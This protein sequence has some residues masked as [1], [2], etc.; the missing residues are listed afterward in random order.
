MNKLQHIPVYIQ[1][2]AISSYLEHEEEN[3]PSELIP[4]A[5][6]WRKLT[7]LINKGYLGKFPSYFMDGN[8]QNEDYLS[9]VIAM[10][11][12]SKPKV[13]DTGINV[14]IILGLDNASAERIDGG[15][16]LDGNVTFDNDRPCHKDD[17]HSE[18]KD[19]RIPT[20]WN[21]AGNDQIEASNDLKEIKTGL[22]ENNFF[23][24]YPR[25]SNKGGVVTV[26]LN[27]SPSL[28]LG[29]FY[30][31]VTIT[32]GTGSEIDLA[33]GFIREETRN[34][35]NMT[36][37]N[38]DLRAPDD[39]VVSWYGKNGLL[40]V[41][42]GKRDDRQFCT[43]GKGDT[44][45]MGFN[46]IR[47]EFFITKNGNYV[48]ELGSIDAFISKGFEGKINT[49][50]LLPCVCFGS[51][52]G[53]S[54]NLGYEQKQM[55]MFDIEHYVK[56][57][58][59]QVMKKIEASNNFNNTKNELNFIDSVIMG[60]LKH[61]GFAET[62]KGLEKDILDLKKEDVS[63]IRRKKF[64]LCELKK[65][66]KEAM[67]ADKFE[68]VERLLTFPFPAFFIENPKIQFRME[69]VQLMYNLDKEIV[70]IKQGVEYASKLKEKFSDEESQYYV[71]H[72]S[73]VFSYPQVRDCPSFS[74]FFDL[75]KIKIVH[76]ISIALSKAHNLP[77]VS[78][79]D[80]LILRTDNKLESYIRE[81][82]KDKSVLLINLLEDYIKH[83]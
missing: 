13:S 68:E 11:A 37:T 17:I 36:I 10:T 26:P 3:G 33:M 5:V 49:K 35:T 73:I 38:I 53:V 12:V 61:N 39:R 51:W 46:L 40:T 27:C 31:E 55:F 76:A 69:I 24:I 75:N 20:C 62:A 65:H 44:V 14:G 82:G 43:F 22:I 15:Y 72:I 32:E 23:N 48:G 45:G 21:F 63:E 1:R 80:L 70:T 67:R 58:K 54:L 74:D 56:E 7:Q 25:S 81:M 66:V 19:L 9:K 8:V 57:N 78:P 2:Q 6:K 42:N 4:D 71:D 64:A 41:W 50:G 60:Y 52:T 29:I 18:I 30:F 77:L 79:L 16:Y 47:D 59:N 83:K 28:Y 34:V